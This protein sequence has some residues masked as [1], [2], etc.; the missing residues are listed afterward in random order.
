MITINKPCSVG[1]SWVG[2][3]FMT[4]E[5]LNRNKAIYAEAIYKVARE[6]ET[7]FKNEMA[8]QERERILAQKVPSKKKSLLGRMFGK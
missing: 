7:R 5:S 6:I 2:N 8:A 1:A 4:Q 3:Y